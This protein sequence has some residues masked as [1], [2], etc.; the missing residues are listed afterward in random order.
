MPLEA[1]GRGALTSLLVDVY[2]LVGVGDHSIANDMYGVDIPTTLEV[3]PNKPCEES[4]T[5]ADFD[6]GALLLPPRAYKVLFNIYI[7]HL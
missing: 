6:A 2:L 1:T 3:V 5:E 7:L 4:T